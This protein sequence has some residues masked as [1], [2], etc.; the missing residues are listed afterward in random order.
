MYMRGSCEKLATFKKQYIESKEYKKMDEQMTG[1][2]GPPR[3]PGETRFFF[4]LLNTVD[5][6]LLQGHKV[7]FLVKR[8]L[9]SS[10]P[11]PSSH[12]GSEGEGNLRMCEK[13]SCL[14]CQ[15]S[16]GCQIVDWPFFI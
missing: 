10:F 3:Y 14:V 15:Q 7:L 13:R 4:T 9:C 11:G 12:S 2:A 1:I 5:A 6:L 16:S 8:V